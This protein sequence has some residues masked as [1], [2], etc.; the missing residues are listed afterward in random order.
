[1]PFQLILRNIIVSIDQFMREMQFAS[2]ADDAGSIVRAAEGMRYA[3]IMVSTIP[4]MC[5]YPF[6][7]KYFTKGVMI[8]SIKG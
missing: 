2:M 3:V 6:V 1:M 8:G 4:I 7:Q 5:I